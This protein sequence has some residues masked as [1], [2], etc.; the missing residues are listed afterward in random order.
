MTTKQD[1]TN[2]LRKAGVTVHRVYRVYEPEEGEQEILFLG[3]VK[4]ERTSTPH[5]AYLREQGDPYVADGW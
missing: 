1:A 4:G 2:L 3:R 5:T